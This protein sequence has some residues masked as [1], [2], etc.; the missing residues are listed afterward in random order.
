MALTDT[1]I[2]KA[3]STDKPYKL[4]DG[5]GLYLLVHPNGSKYWRMQYTF[6]GKRRLY[7]IGVYPQVS[8]AEARLARDQARKLVRNGTDPV[9]AKRDAKRQAKVR[10]ANSFE[11]I[12]REWHDRQAGR[13]TPDHAARVIMSLEREVFPYI[14]AKPIAEATAPMIM[15]VVQRVERR[16]A[17]DVA[18]RILQRV[19][20]VYRY[21]IQRGYATHN[22]ASDLKGSV[23]TRKVTHRLALSR[24]EL[25]EFLQKV[26]AYPGHRLV[27]L[28]LK[29]MALTFVRT[30]ELR[31]ARWSEFDFDNALWRIPAERTKMQRDHLV[32]LSRQTLDALE[33]LRSLTGGFDLLFPN[34]RDVS[35]PMSQN[36]M[37]H[38]MYRIGFAKRGTVHGFRAVA[39]TILNE[40]GFRPDV[41]ERQLAHIERNKVR[42]AY[43]RAEYLDERRR[44]MQA[45]ANVLDSL[46]TCAKVIPLRVKEPA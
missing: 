9:H 7:A 12:A 30:S 1:K 38:A 3:R 34:E 16:D 40:M 42:A 29:L 18:A 14:G 8:L 32:P 35:K 41:I 6:A 45:W 27:G 17:L 43:H 24:A 33:E 5:Q 20:A 13:W 44:M 31:G 46:T 37:R 21:A 19:S 2:R 23:K 22:P 15:E 11:R 25:P 26:E 28:A 4:F 10:A 36:T 39:S